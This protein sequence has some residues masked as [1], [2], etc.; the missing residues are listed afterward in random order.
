[1]VVRYDLIELYDCL[2][3]MWGR[4]K[5]TFDQNSQL[6]VHCADLQRIKC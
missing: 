2:Y 6:Y 1:M 5:Y 4:K 3:S